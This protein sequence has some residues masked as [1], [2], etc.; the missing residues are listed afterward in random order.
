MENRAL[1]KSSVSFFSEIF[2]NIDK[3]FI[4]GG[5][6][7]LKFYDT[8]EFSDALLTALNVQNGHTFLKIYFIFQ[9]PS[10]T[11]LE[12]LSIPNLDHSEK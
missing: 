10:Y 3:I 2:D 1:R 4:F 8:F 5:N 11:K 7:R 6:N 9:K 12:S